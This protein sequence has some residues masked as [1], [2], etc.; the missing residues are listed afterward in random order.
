M[1]RFLLMESPTGEGAT[2]ESYGFSF[3]QALENACLAVSSA[4]ESHLSEFHA[5]EHVVIEE[6]AATLEELATLVLS[7]LVSQANEKELLVKHVE[8]K[9]FCKGEDS[10]YSARVLAMGGPL[11]L[12]TSPRML[13][14]VELAEGAVKQTE[15]G[16]WS[17]QAS[18]LFA[19][20]SVAKK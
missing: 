8:L 4:Q 10:A 1:D 3:Q 2:L 11:E 12:A 17:I 16:A 20:K 18:I 19:E 15:N 5:Y 14:S 13:D 7:D 6:H 9:D